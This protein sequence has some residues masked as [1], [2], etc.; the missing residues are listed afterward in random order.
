MFWYSHIITK[1][2]IVFMCFI[3]GHKHCVKASRHFIFVQ[4]KHKYCSLQYIDLIQFQNLMIQEELTGMCKIICIRQ[5]SNCINIVRISCSYKGVCGV[6]WHSCCKV[7][8]N[9]CVLSKDRSS[10]TISCKKLSLL[11][12]WLTLKFTCYKI[13]IHFTMQTVTI[14]SIA[15]SAKHSNWNI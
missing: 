9:G 4:F 6:I 12:N 3:V 15:E 14:L 10:I 8:F 1:A 2:C 13:N 7:S 11:T 5:N